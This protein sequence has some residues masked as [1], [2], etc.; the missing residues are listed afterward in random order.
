MRG[1]R[2]SGR[3]PIRRLMHVAATRDGRL[4]IYFMARRDHHR[5]PVTF[6]PFALISLCRCTKW[7]AHQKRSTIS[8][9]EDSKRLL[10]ARL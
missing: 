4:V 5:R 8:L 2:A 1:E 7:P 3:V 6:S 10:A 9:H